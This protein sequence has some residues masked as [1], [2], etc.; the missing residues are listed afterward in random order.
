MEFL[1]HDLLDAT[2]VFFLGETPLPAVP[3]TYDWTATSHLP[4]P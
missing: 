3:K 1:L 4:A 2:D